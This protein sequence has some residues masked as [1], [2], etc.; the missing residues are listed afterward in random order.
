MTDAT[1]TADIAPTEQ[2]GERQIWK[3]ASLW[4]LFLGPFFF[5]SYGFANWFASQQQVSHIVFDWE[6]YIPFIPWTIIPYWFIDILYAISLFICTTKKELDSLAKRLLTAQVIAVICFILFPLGFSFERPE[7]TGL[8]GGMFTTLSSFDQPFNQAPSLHIALLVILWVSYSRHLPRLLLWPFH[9]LSALIAISVLTTYQHHFVDVPTGALL[10][11]FSV[12]LWPANGNTM[13]NRI[14]SNQIERRW[15]LATYY[16][17]AAVA[18]GSIGFTTGGFGL[19]LLWP[20][21]SLMLVAIYYIYVGSDGFQKSENGKLNAATK[22]LLLPY[23]IGVRFNSRVWTRNDSI[24]DH[25]EDGVWLGRF[26]SKENIKNNNYKTIIDLTAEFDAPSSKANWH[27][28]PTLDLITPSEQI[29]TKA[30]RLIE[31]SRLKGTVL[32]TCALGYSRSAIAVVA[33][34]LITRR[35]ENANSAI[36]IVKLKRPSIILKGT[37]LEVL[38]NLAKK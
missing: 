26:P 31:E 5:V 34:L 22:W 9:V 12:W 4:L 21:V 25:I 30:A 13:F 33:W 7:T 8:L 11:W 16:V 23:L 15:R 36:E 37:D 17:I 27:T 3:R 19:W 18:L 6:Q 32:V 1:K 29:L 2:G 38:N 35:A 14:R 20:A 10:G 24:S 28:V